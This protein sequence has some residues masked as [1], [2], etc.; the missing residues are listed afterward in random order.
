MKLKLGWQ[1]ICKFKEEKTT[2]IKQRS[3]NTWN[4]NTERKIDREWDRSK[5]WRNDALKTPKRR[6]SITQVQKAR[7]I[8]ERKTTAMESRT[9]FS[10]LYSFWLSYLCWMLRFAFF[11]WFLCSLSCVYSSYTKQ[12]NNALI[13]YLQ[14]LP[15]NS[16]WHYLPVFS[17]Y[18]YIKLCKIFIL[19]LEINFWKSRKIHINSHIYVLL[20]LFFISTYKF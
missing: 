16:L 10:L 17:F 12:Y 18:L 3:V 15:T 7:R 6:K 8:K 19:Y 4:W 2:K 9:L 11:S 5:V 14:E 1:K 13:I 20:F